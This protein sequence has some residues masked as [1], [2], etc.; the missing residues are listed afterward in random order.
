MTRGIPVSE[1]SP[2]EPPLASPARLRTRVCVQRARV[3]MR[4]LFELF[5]RLSLLRPPADDC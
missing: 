1:R 5:N 3:L 2:L 4:M